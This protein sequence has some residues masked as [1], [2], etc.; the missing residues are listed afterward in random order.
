MYFKESFGRLL[1]QIR[2]S[3]NITQEALAEMV[4]IHPRQ[5]SKLETGEHFPNATTLENICVALSIS[6]RDLFNFDLKEISEQTGTGDKYIYKAVVEGN[7]VYLDNSNFRK[8]KVEKVN[9]SNEI[10]SKMINLARKTGKPI[11]VQYYNDNDNYKT[12]EYYPDGSYKIVKNDEDIKIENLISKIKNLIMNK[13]MFEF[14][15]LVVDAIHNNTAL[16]KL[17]YLISGMLIGRK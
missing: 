7:V 9:S 13:D 12:I 17:Q 10:D 2:K 11:T 15:S 16:E 8:Q 6:P 1:K 14:F 5:V 3:R 4:G